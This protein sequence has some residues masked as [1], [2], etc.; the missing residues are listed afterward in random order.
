MVEKDCIIV[1]ST[2]QYGCRGSSGAGFLYQM[3]MRLPSPTSRSSSSSV[4]PAARMA[5][6]IEATTRLCRW[7]V[8]AGHEVKCSGTAGMVRGNNS[9]Y[10]STGT[11]IGMDRVLVSTVYCTY[12]PICKNNRYIPNSQRP[13]LFGWM[14]RFEVKLDYQYIHIYVDIVWLARSTLTSRGKPRHGKLV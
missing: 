14:V 7:M 6:R 13:Y 2:M 5:G 11:N 10:I 3:S 4:T 12:V 9:M 8:N 1:G